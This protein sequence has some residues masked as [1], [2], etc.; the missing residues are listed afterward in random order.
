MILFNVDHVYCVLSVVR[1]RLTKLHPN[2][3]SN[4]RAVSQKTGSAYEM[5][6]GLLAGSGRKQP[7]LFDTAKPIPQN[8]QCIL[9]NEPP[10]ALPHA[11][12]P[13]HLT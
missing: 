1:P 7:T 11:D 10:V 13:L 3:V 12:L 2:L 6:V 8:V 4:T 5:E 9:P